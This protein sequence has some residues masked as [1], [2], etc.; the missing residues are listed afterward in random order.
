MDLCLL[1]WKAIA[2][3]IAA[4][5]AASI[6]SF[7]AF[8]ISDRWNNQKGSEVI[9]N[10][11]KEAIYQISELSKFYQKNLNNI[12]PSNVEEII[13]EYQIIFKDVIHKIDFI[14]NSPINRDDKKNLLEVALN[15]GT[16]NIIYIDKLNSKKTS[17]ELE[18]LFLD[19]FKNF[20]KQKQIIIKILMDYALY[21]K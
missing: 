3:I 9:A 2:P 10:E 12:N 13:N 15:F 4:T 8:K 20:T 21:K 16:S 14:F 1:D 17:A 6:A 19:S 11:A 5:I 18:E 7:T